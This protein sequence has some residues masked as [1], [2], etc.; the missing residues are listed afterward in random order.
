[1]EVLVLSEPVLP[2]VFAGELRARSAGQYIEYIQPDFQL[3][4]STLDPEPGDPKVGTEGDE[5]DEPDEPRIGDEPE[6]EAPPSLGDPELPAQAEPV[7]VAVIDTGVDTTHPMLAGRISEDGWN[8]PADS[9]DVYDPARPNEAS[10]GTHIAGLI[11]SAAEQTGADVTILP[12]KVFENGHAYTSDIIAA[13]LFADAQG[14]DVINCSFGSAANNRAL[15]EAVAA[16]DALFVC[17]AGNARLDLSLTPVYPA[18]YDLPNVLSVASVNADGGFSYFSNYSDTIIDVAAQGRDVL[19]AVPGGETGR[20]SGTSQSAGTVTGI[21]AAALSLTDADTAADLRARLLDTADRLDNLENKVTGGRR[22]NLVNALAGETGSNLSLDP[23]DDFDVHGVQPTPSEQW[24]LYNLSGPVVKAVAG[25]NHTLALK[26]DGSVWA[27]GAN[28]Y[29]Q[30]GTGWDYDCDTLTQVIG[31]TDIVDIAAGYEHSIALSGDGTL[32]TWGGSYYGQLGNGCCGLWGDY[33]PIPMEVPLWDPMIYAVDATTNGCFAYSGHNDYKFAWGEVGYDD[34]AWAFDACGI[35]RGVTI[36]PQVLYSDDYE[37]YNT[38][39]VTSGWGHFLGLAD[40]GSVLSWGNNN[41]GQLGDGTTTY[42]SEPDTISGLSDMVDIAAGYNHSLALD[43]YGRFWAWGANWAGQL[44][45][46]TDTDSLVPVPVDSADQFTHMAA[47]SDF[48]L[49]LTDTGEVVSFGGNCCGQLGVGDLDNRD[50]PTLIPG[51]TGIVQISAGDSHA[52]AVDAYGNIWTWGNNGSGQLGLSNFGWCSDTPVQVTE[53]NPDLDIHWPPSKGPL[54]LRGYVGYRKTFSQ[55]YTVISNQ[56]VTANLDVSWS[57]GTIGLNYAV[58]DE[59]TNALT[60]GWVGQWDPSS[61]FVF[62]MEAY[63]RYTIVIDM[64]EGCDES[65]YALTLSEVLPELPEPVVQPIYWS[66]SAGPLNIDGYAGYRRNDS[67][68]YRITSDETVAAV[69]DMTKTG[70]N[71]YLNYSVYDDQQNCVASGDLFQDTSSMT[72]EMEAFTE[73]TVEV[74]TPASYWAPY[75]YEIFYSLTLSEA[76]PVTVLLYPN[77]V[78]IPKS[79][80]VTVETEVI[81][82]DEYGSILMGEEVLFA[83]Y[84]PYTGVNIDNTTGLITVSSDASPGTLRVIAVWGQEYGEAGLTLNAAGTPELPGAALALDVTEGG[85]YAVS[86]KGTNISS[87]DSA[88]FTL[89]Y[90]PY[91]LEL[92][93]FAAQTGQESITAGTVAG[94]PLEI[95][96]HADG[97]LTFTVDKSIPSGQ[98]WSGALTLLTFEALDDGQTT[99]TIGGGG[100]SGALALRSGQ[101]E[102]TPGAS[103]AQ[104]NPGEQPDNNPPQQQAAP[105]PPGGLGMIPPGDGENDEDDE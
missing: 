52:V 76:K 64:P 1:M 41:S 96:S 36:Y 82:R 2:S 101:A 69:L 29:G 104:E 57:N 93:D 20:M 81:L 65:W 42:R 34:Y 31:L 17:A 5:P 74:Y 51:L 75:H 32:Y 59:Q 94:T 3:R 72:F 7:L 45:D 56:T 67:E 103:E 62:E 88:E 73:Y 87:F 105:P 79:G 68:V 19:S 44:G 55:E 26:E 6:E 54:T 12:L 16:S 8:F 14:A 83:C 11:A 40:E 58:Y 47:G 77:T 70:G 63:A 38:A 80:T 37:T 100:D 9:P 25:G 4:I 39:K 35:L 23:E 15:A 90:D 13:V 61:S 22:V 97:T 95:L 89:T 86:I 53:E 43:A 18:C 46:G 92:L 48:T 85:Q 50:T 91:M 60:A 30:C 71:N 98:A 33:N 99:V 10:H 21:A 84:P 102:E 28:H 78:V 66:P 49:G 27:C 24:E